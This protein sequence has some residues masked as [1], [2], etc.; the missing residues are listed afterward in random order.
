MA[1][2]QDS[3]CK[4]H[5]RG[6]FLD[7]SRFGCQRWMFKELETWKFRPGRDNSQDVVVTEMGLIGGRCGADV[8]L[9]IEIYTEYILQQ[10]CI[11]IGFTTQ[12]FVSQDPLDTG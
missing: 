10:T 5:G 2:S 11:R 9:F 7:I 4:I 12:T 8:N 3:K 1:R 6:E